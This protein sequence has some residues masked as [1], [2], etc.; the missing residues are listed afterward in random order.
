MITVIGDVHGKY[1]KYKKITKKH[2]FTV[3]LGDFGFSEWQRL[4]YDDD[5]DFNRHKVMGGN[6]DNY[7]ICIHSNHYLG[8]FGCYTLNN[9]KFFFVRGGISIDKVYREVE[10]VNG[11]PRSWW[12]QEQLTFRQMNECL[13]LYYQEKP[14][15]VITHSCPT[16]LVKRLTNPDLLVKFGFDKGFEDSTS[17]FL[18]VLFNIHE[19]TL[20]IHGHM[21]KSKETKIGDTKFISLNE[22]EVYEI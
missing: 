17:S 10:R 16:R 11:G 18:D 9:L 21:H 13:K 4:D 22:L 20:W 8:D 12:S 7:D 6:H 3:Q 14:D 19:P 2:D 1:D 5:I 15:F